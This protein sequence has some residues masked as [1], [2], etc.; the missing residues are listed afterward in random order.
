[1]DQRGLRA[2]LRRC[3]TP[4]GR[5]TRGAL[6]DILPQ[7]AHD[8]HR[9]RRHGPIWLGY[10]LGHLQD[11]GRVFRAL[12]YNK[13][14]LVLHMLRR[15]LGDEVFFR[16]LRRLYRDSRFSKIGTGDVQRAFEEESG[17][18]LD[19]FFSAGSRAPTPAVHV[20]VP[21]SKRRRPRPRPRR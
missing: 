17:Q 13:S 7:A 12:V 10:R 14:A 8:R 15:W 3:S 21:R 9:Q 2:V 16:G 4:S 18:P 1:M 20:A 19:R 6:E 5:S 11:D